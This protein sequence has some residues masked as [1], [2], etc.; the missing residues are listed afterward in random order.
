MT[1]N[2]IDDILERL[3]KRLVINRQSRQ[4]YRAHELLIEEATSRARAEAYENAIN[5]VLAIKKKLY[6]GDVA[7]LKEIEE[8]WETV[9]SRDF[10]KKIKTETAYWKAYGDFSRDKKTSNH[11][12]RPAYAKVEKLPPCPHPLRR[13]WICVACYYDESFREFT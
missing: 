6:D 8:Y 1:T 3:H 10:L 13:N 12:T 11:T 4:A 7:V 2:Y 5:D 9:K